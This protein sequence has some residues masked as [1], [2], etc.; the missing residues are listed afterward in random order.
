MAENVQSKIRDDLGPIG[1]LWTIIEKVVTQENSAE[2]E[3]QVSLEDIIRLIEKSVMLLGQAN[4]KVAYF[5]R[6]NILHVSLNYSTENFGH[7]CQ[8]QVLDNTKAQKEALE[9]VREA[10][11]TK[12]KPFSAGLPAR[13]K[14]SPRGAAGN[15]NRIPLRQHFRTQQQQRWQRN[16]KS[17]TTNKSNGKTPK[18]NG[19]YLLQHFSRTSSTRKFRT[20]S[21]FSNGNVPGG[22]KTKCSSRRKDF[23][24][25][26][27]LEKDHKRSGIFKNSEGIQNSLVKDTSPGKNSSEYIPKRKS[28]ISSGKKDQINVGEG[29]N[30]E[31]L[32]TQR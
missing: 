20:R 21:S 12:K 6:L 30:K 11:K 3:D 10:G 24:F 29:S 4:I 25:R 5:R 28:E 9:M 19:N 18:T 17:Q 23:P 26:P 14:Q 32:A 16:T 2:K 7:Q 27:F 15:H 1:S 31:R 13:N 8:K 22:I